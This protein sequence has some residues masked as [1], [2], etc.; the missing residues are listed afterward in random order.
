MPP[1]RRKINYHSENLNMGNSCLE[2]LLPASLQHSIRNIQCVQNHCYLLVDRN[3][4][5][6]T[7]PPDCLNLSAVL[8]ICDIF[9]RIRI[10]LTSGYGSNSGSDSFLQ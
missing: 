10:P 4:I 1:V 8:G 3:Q 6:L 7:A 9:V 5:C 2:L